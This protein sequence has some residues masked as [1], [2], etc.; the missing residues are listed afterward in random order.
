[1][2]AL[3]SDKKI[4]RKKS[5]CLFIG[6]D[7]KVINYERGGLVFAFNFHPTNSYEGYWLTVPSV[8]KY[9]VIMSTDEGDFGGYDRISKEYIYTA[10]KH[11]DKKAKLQIYLPPR[12]AI[13]L[14]KIKES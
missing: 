11:P 9:K 8:G 13:C 4:F 10:E 2:V 1:M 6:N 7:D 14:V 5:K 12:T 3:T